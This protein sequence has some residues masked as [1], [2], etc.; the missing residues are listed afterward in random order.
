MKL[1]AAA[2]R[3]HTPTSARR[4]IPDSL[5]PGLRLVIQPRPSGAKSWA[6]RFRRPDGRPAKLTLGSVD[7]SDKEAA[8]DPVLG[9]PLTLRQARQLAAEIDRKRARGVDVIEEHKAQRQRQRSE[10]ETRAVNCF[11]ACARAFFTDYKTR[12]GQRP[13]RWRDEASAL[14]LH[15]PPNSDPA[16]IEPVIV[17][18]G[19]ADIWASKPVAE[20]DAHDIH[21]VVSEARKHGNDGRAR[22][23]YAALSVLF[24]WLL[25]ERRVAV[26]PCVGVWRPGPP[27]AR[28]RVLDNNEI[29]AFWRAC[30]KIGTPYGAMFRLLLLTGCRLREAANMLHSELNGDGVWTIPGPRTKNSRILALPLPQLALDVIASCPAIE[31]SDFVFTLSG[32][33][34]NGFSYAKRSLDKAM[35]EII[36]R[37][38][39]WRLHDLRRTAASGMAALGVQLPVIEKVLNHVGG[40]FGGVVGIYQRHTFALEKA[41]AL[42]RWA[43]HLQGLVSRQPDNVV[44]MKKAPA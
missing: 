15:Y 17:K 13:R 35:A 19:L 12:R 22:K 26:N 39:D 44:P 37:Q 9:A 11:G 5:A 33:P 31:N 20:I 29:V 28:E 42:A 43:K 2:V 38:V 30:D 8:D 41:D 21:T 14:G 36:G 24:S 32:Q 4:E 23:R 25:R 7:L 18:G 34:L 1:T 10:T 6:M 27:P 3:K 40:S 16:K